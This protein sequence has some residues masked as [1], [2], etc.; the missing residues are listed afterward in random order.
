MI[1]EF[2]ER[3]RTR[4]LA[5]RRRFALLFASCITA[6]IAVC[7]GITLPARLSALALN[8]DVL[9]DQADATIDASKDTV[10]PPSEV[11][12]LINVQETFGGHPPQAAEAA[13]PAD[14]ESEVSAAD[15]GAM[16]L[17]ATSTNEAQ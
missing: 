10:A 1:I 16:I 5:E 15:F 2:L 7:W 8:F 4:P 13:L 11:Q 3:L 12:D 17:V 14:S 9:A 6:I